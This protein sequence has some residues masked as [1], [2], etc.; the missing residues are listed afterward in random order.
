MWF[1][2]NPEYLYTIWPI[3]EAH[4]NKNPQIAVSMENTPNAPPIRITTQPLSPSQSYVF[5]ALTFSSF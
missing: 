5:K 2:T 1:K 4:L 3:M